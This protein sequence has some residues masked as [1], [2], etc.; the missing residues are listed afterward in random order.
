MGGGIMEQECPIIVGRNTKVINLGN[1]EDIELIQLEDE[2]VS[3][4]KRN[5]Y[6]HR[7]SG[8]W[9]KRENKI[10]YFK[11]PIF[12]NQ[13]LKEL[14]GEKITLYFELPS[15]H[16]QLAKMKINDQTVYGLLSQYTRQK[17]KK[18]MLLKD[19]AVKAGWEQQNFLR[20]LSEEYGNQ[21]LLEE[22]KRLLVRELYTQE[23]DR[24]DD[25][26]VVEIDQGKVRLS[27]LV[28][29]EEEFMLKRNLNPIKIPGIQTFDIEDISTLL[30]VKSDKC[31]EQYFNRVKQLKINKLLTELKGEFNLKLHA[32]DRKYYLDYDTEVKKHLKKYNLF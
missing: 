5:N 1:L 21:P 16:Y 15:V 14:V 26:L 25:E 13:I 22:Y 20:F 24:Q 32:I 18:Y 10:Y 6:H 30:S 29:Y 19:W 7:V 8:Y 2:T 12:E 9:L 23:E 28:D 3:P 11:A 31:F 17:D 4:I 27:P